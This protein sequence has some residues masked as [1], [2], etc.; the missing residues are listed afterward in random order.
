[1]SGTTFSIFNFSQPLK[2]S[3]IFIS[4]SNGKIHNSL[5]H[6]LVSLII[7]PVINQAPYFLKEPDKIITKLI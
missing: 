4:I 6:N 2:L 3:K 1:M 7:R 5:D